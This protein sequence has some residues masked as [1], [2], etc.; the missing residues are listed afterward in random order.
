VNV[1]LAW[2]SDD[3]EA[4]TNSDGVV[5]VQDLVDVITNWGSCT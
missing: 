5:D 3:A 4:D 1:I 2:G